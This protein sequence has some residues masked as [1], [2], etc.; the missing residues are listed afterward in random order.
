M[1]GG[2][3][4]S[5]V[6]GLTYASHQRSGADL[7]LDS[8]ARISDRFIASDQTSAAGMALGYARVDE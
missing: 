6:S 8:D 7:Q 4:I 2:Y 5:S 3:N 1:P